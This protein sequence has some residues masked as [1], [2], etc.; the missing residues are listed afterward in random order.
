MDDGKLCTIKNR[1][2]GEKIADLLKNDIDKIERAL[3]IA[4]KGEGKM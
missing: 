4:I 2:V 3:S 1:D